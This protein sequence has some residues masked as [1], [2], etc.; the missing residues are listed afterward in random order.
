[1]QKVIFTLHTS[2]GCKPR[3]VWRTS[4]LVLAKIVCLSE[5]RFV[6]CCLEIFNDPFFLSFFFFPE[7]NPEKFKT[8]FKNFVFYGKVSVACCHTCF[9]TYVCVVGEESLFL[10]QQAQFTFKS[11]VLALKTDFFVFVLGW[12]CHL[13]TTKGP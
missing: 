11:I 5:F 8:R 12:Q 13:P 2:G 7:A 10:K 6:S 9:L 3:T 4:F 1:M